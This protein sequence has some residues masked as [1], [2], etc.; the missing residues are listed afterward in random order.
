MVTGVSG[1]G[2][3]QAL[4]IME[5]MDYYCI[6]NL[7]P[8]LIETFLQLA[9]SNT[10][11]NIEKIAL[12]IDIRSGIDFAGIKT[13][14]SNLRKDGITCDVLFI[15]AEDDTIVRRFKEVKRTHPLARKGNLNEG[16]ASERNIIQPIKEISNY[17]IDTT[18]LSIWQLKEKVRE[19]FIEDNSENKFPITIVSFGFKNGVPNDADMIFD[20]RFITNPF[21]IPELKG[22]TGLEKEV[23]SFV[24]S[25]NE[26]RKFLD[27]LVDMIDYLIPLY[28]MEGKGQLTIA[29]GCTGGKHRSVSIATALY[30]HL[31]KEGHSTNIEHR[32]LKAMRQ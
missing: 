9:A 17:I 31:D 29:I 32:S 7:P 21:Y 4:H 20:V 1:A 10:N 8:V 27:K 13:I 11:L 25:S 3:T 16:I 5:D 26:S 2:K 28:V 24:L 12:G 19:L 18:K 6:D 23:S 14:I 15:D 22:K 30:T